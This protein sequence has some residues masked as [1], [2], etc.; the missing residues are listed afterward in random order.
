VLPVDSFEEFETDF[1]QKLHAASFGDAPYGEPNAVSAATKELRRK[2]GYDIFTKT[3]LRSIYQLLCEHSR[4]AQEQLRVHEIKKQVNPKLVTLLNQMEAVQAMK[5]SIERSEPRMQDLPLTETRGRL[6]E[7]LLDYES[8]IRKYQDYFNSMVNPAVRKAALGK[9]RWEPVLKPDNYSL[10]SLK[11]KAPDKWIYDKLDQMLT[12]K[13]EPLR[14]SKIT[15]YRVMSAL[16]QSVE[17]DIKPITFKLHRRRRNGA[18]R[19]V[20]K[21]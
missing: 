21:S 9:V 1:L 11:K 5:R 4:L 16:L 3:F 12:M 2:Q 13:M 14:I 10:S 8:D 17:L 6:K 20:T 19:S 18:K 7:A 15:R